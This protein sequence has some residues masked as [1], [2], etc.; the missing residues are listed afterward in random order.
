VGDAG[1][2]LTMSING[3]VRQRAKVPPPGKEVAVLVAAA[4]NV[5]TLLPGDVLLTGVPA[6][7]AGA[8]GPWLQA[9]DEVSVSIDAI[10]TLTNK[11]EHG[12]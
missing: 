7:T 10:G 9:G 11:V 5:M 12:D 3:Q 8:G 4:S 1:L 6:G 2:E